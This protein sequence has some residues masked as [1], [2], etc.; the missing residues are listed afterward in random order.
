MERLEF[1]TVGDSRAATVVRDV[2]RHPGAVA[3][4]PVLDGDRIVLVRNHRVAVDEWLYELCAGKLER[5]EEPAAAAAR[6]L[7]EETGYSAGRIEPL[8]RFYTSPGF[9]DELMHVFEATDLTEVPR[10]LEPGERIEVEVRTLAEV[11]DMVGDGRIRDGKTIA[12]LM[13]WLRRR[14]AAAP[15]SGGSAGCGGSGHAGGAGA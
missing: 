14:K 6:E 1:A 11:L 12:G 10:R 3:V 2:V 9:A 7:E 8:G 15:E 4:V 13:L 5:G